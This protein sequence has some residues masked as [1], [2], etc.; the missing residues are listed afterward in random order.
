MKLNP[1][2][3]TIQNV[4]PELVDHDLFVWSP[5]VSTWKTNL[6]ELHSNWSINLDNLASPWQEGNEKWGVGNTDD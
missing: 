2:C 6:I 1:T 3:Q 5:G 4:H